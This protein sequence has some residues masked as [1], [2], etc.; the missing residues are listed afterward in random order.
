MECEETAE[1]VSEAISLGY[2]LF[3]LAREYGNEHVI[4]K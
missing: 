4:G 2:E 1:I 3:D